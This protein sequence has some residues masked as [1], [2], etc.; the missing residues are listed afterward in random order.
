MAG[1]QNKM[2][3]MGMVPGQTGGVGHMG[4]MQGMQSNALLTQINQ[5]NQGNMNPQMVQMGSGQLGTQMGGGQPQHNM[6]VGIVCITF[7]Q[8]YERNE[9]KY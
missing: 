1:M 5:I 8:G 2:Q 7:N 9:M 3:G 4:Q 6:Q